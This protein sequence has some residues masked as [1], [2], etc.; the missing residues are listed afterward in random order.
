MTNVFQK[1]EL[2]FDVL[3]KVICNLIMR[4]HI[5]L[6]FLEVKLKIIQLMGETKAF[7]SF[8]ACVSRWLHS[9]RKWWAKSEI[10]T[11]AC[12][13][14]TNSSW[15]FLIL[16]EKCKFLTDNYLELKGEKRD[17]KNW[18]FQWIV[19]L[20]VV[21]IWTHFTAKSLRK[22][23]LI[24]VIEMKNKSWDVLKTQSSGV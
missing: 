1:S 8:S 18:L 21:S 2:S 13:S 11:R 5:M 23:K 15:N 20:E 12:P 17:K 6:I 9:W 10:T 14:S 7:E 19:L 24:S 3:M 4:C 16:E 22:L